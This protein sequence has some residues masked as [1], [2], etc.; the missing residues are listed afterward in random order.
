L[1]NVYVYQVKQ[2]LARMSQCNYEY[3]HYVI[4]Q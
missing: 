4:I 3:N 1:T 2:T